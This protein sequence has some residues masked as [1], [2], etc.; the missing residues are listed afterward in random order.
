[1]EKR[2]ILIP[3]AKR[4]RTYVRIPLEDRFWSF[5]KKTD[6]CWLWIG[7]AKTEFGYGLINSG[8][9][10]R[11]TLRA[12][13]V[14]WEIHYGPI[15]DGLFVCHKC[16]NPACVNPSH[17]FLGSNTDN[18]L[19]C[20]RKGRAKFNHPNRRTG[21]DHHS[22][23]LSNKDREAILK[24]ARTHNPPLSELS[25]KYSV[26]ISAIHMIVKSTRDAN[27]KHYRRKISDVQAEAIRKQHLVNGVSLV[28]LAECYNTT[29][30]TIWRIVRN[31][32]SY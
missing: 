17:L 12:H 4:N 21:E 30:S 29:K 27:I 32:T 6:G 11:R 26:S 18:M 31:K 23:K 7:K 2:Q 1:M 20:A 22:S 28:N 19:D 25:R 16:D 5:V 9:T 13:R 24:E 8:G 3:S 14:S 15:R 10:N